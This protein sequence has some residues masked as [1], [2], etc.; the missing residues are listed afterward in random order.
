MHL[1]D[2]FEDIRFKDIRKLN[3]F[4]LSY[5]INNDQCFSD[6]FKVQVL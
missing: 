1:A 4:C 3:N 2:F 6:I 5:F